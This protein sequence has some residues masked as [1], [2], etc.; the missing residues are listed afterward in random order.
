M[1]E[2]T[3]KC[4]SMALIIYTVSI[5][6]LTFLHAP[7]SAMMYWFITKHIENILPPR[8]ACACVCI[9][10]WFVEIWSCFR[11]SYHPIP[12]PFACWWNIFWCFTLY[13]V[14]IIFPCSASL[15]LLFHFL[16]VCCPAYVENGTRQDFVRNFLSLNHVPILILRDWAQLLVRHIQRTTIHIHINAQIGFTIFIQK[17]WSIEYVK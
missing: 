15:R 14:D 12:L 13:I 16:S 2:H 5:L 1:K 9:C 6:N 3:G 4:A 10:L 8:C 7:C 11:I 17:M